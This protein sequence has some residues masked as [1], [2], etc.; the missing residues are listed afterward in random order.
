VRLAAGR[1]DELSLRRLDKVCA[2]SYTPYDRGSE[3]R[4]LHAN[5][6]FHMLIAATTRND[7]LVATVRDLLQEIERILHFGLAFRNRTDEMRHEHDALIIALTQGDVNGA[8]KAI[9][10]EMSS[11]RSMVLD[12]LMSSPSLLDV[13]ITSTYPKVDDA[14]GVGPFPAGKETRSLSGRRQGV[15][16]LP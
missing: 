3:E 14:E 8:E 2:E 4:F 1:V 15:R 9:C 7:R 12:A 10:E 6:E 5:S 13:N 11:S 16:P